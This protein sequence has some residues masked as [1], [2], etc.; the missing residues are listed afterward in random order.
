MSSNKELRFKRDYDKLVQP[1]HRYFIYNCGDKDEAKDLT[2]EVFIKYW[3]KID[4]IDEKGV[5]SY[6]Y[7]IAKNLIIN[8]Y[9]RDKV[10]LKFRERIEEDVDKNDP[11]YI[12]EYKDYKTR[13]EQVIGD[14]PATQ[15]E[16]LLMHRI[17]G[18][19]YKEIAEKIGIS[20]KA[21]EKRM[22]LALKRIKNLSKDE[23]EGR[24]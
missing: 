12:L 16:V 15:R 14:M 7:M 9:K 11:Q 5:S 17:D 23:L 2:Q 22:N 6:I 8:K 4:S 10:K 20:V 18:Y 21:V 24:V 13:L 1:I 3:Q 19:K